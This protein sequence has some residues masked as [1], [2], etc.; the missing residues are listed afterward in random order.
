M[1]K[2]RLLIAF[3]W[4]DKIKILAVIFSPPDP[5]QTL[6]HFR[7]SH[8]MES[9]FGI[10]KKNRQQHARKGY[11]DTLSYSHSHKGRTSP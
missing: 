7:P 9:H 8:S 1:S 11:G 3:I 5:R 6:Y 4:M 10:M 2:T